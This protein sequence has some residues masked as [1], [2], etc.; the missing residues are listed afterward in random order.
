MQFFKYIIFLNL[1]K[2]EQLKNYFQKK[3]NV[4]PKLFWEFVMFFQ[5]STS[6]HLYSTH[7]LTY[8]SYFYGHK[9]FVWLWN[10]GMMWITGKT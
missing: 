7:F 2:V 1:E 10:S 6:F 3:E 9:T 4:P 5:L 8:N